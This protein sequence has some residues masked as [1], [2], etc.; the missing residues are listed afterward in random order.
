L[1]YLDPAA[2]QLPLFLK[3]RIKSEMLKRINWQ[4]C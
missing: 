1:I 4:V 2:Y 3:I